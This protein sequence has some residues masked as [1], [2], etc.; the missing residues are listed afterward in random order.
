MRLEATGCRSVGADPTAQVADC[1]GVERATTIAA[2]VARRHA[3][4]R[5]FPG[6][7]GI[8]DNR[9]QPF[10]AMHQGQ[11]PARRFPPD[12]ECSVAP[13]LPAVMRETQERKGLR[14]PFAAPLPILIVAQGSSGY[15][16]V[17][18]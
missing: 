5:W 2:T 4:G 8:G 16:P 14:L 10:V 7:H 15:T 17:A 3:T 1:G 6:S 9:L 18:I 12:G 11:Q 13:S